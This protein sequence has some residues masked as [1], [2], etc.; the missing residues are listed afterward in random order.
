MFC[1][2]ILVQADVRFCHETA[3]LI[4]LL[5]ASRFIYYLYELKENKIQKQNCPY[6]A[7]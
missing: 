3:V 6:A 5:L 4:S 1:L 7:E 2:D